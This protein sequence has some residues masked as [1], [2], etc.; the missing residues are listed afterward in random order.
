MGAD[1]EAGVQ[2]EDAAVGPGGQQTTLIWG[3]GE[4]GIVVLEAGIDIF[5]GRGSRGGRANREGEAMGLVEVVVRVLAKDNGLDRVE[6]G[7]AGPMAPVSISLA[8]ID[9]EKR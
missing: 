9:M 5:Q 6:G 7:V 4:G 8:P 3:W 2:E 1:R